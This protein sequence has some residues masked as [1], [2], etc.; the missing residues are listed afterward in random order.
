[1]YTQECHKAQSYSYIEK[2]I[3]IYATDCKEGHVL[4]KLQRGLTAIET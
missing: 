3:Y 2:F 1:M 4:R